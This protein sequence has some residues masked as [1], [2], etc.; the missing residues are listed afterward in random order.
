M[1]GI[2]ATIATV[3]LLLIVAVSMLLAYVAFQGIGDTST[4]IVEEEA[5]A[6]VGQST[7]VTIDNAN[8]EKVFVR[9][10]GNM[11][12]NDTLVLYVD[13]KYIEI[14][15]VDLEK[16]KVSEL[17]LSGGFLAAG[18]YDFRLSIPGS[19][20]VSKINVKKSNIITEPLF[21]ETLHEPISIFLVLDRSGSMRNDNKMEDA[22]D[23]ATS[24]VDIT[25]DL[26]EVG[27]VSFSTSARLDQQLTIDKQAVKDEIDDLSAR[28]WTAI[29][30][31]I[32]TATNELAVYG[33][34]KKIQVLLTDGR[35]TRNS[36]PEG[37]AAEAAAQNVTI[38]AI[39]LGD[40]VDEPQLM[41]IANLTGGNYYF[42]PTSEELMSIFTQ[43]AVQLQEGW[44]E[45]GGANIDNYGATCYS[46]NMCTKFSS[47]VYP[48]TMMLQ[49]RKFTFSGAYVAEASA[50]LKVSG[51]SCNSCAQLPGETCLAND[52]RLHLTAYD[53][54]DQIIDEKIG[55][56]AGSKGTG[57][58]EVKET[59]LTPVATKS[60]TFQVD[61]GDCCDCNVDEVYADNAYLS[62]SK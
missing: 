15:P 46:P 19:K 51:N 18:T 32:Y 44:V 39:G 59:W 36:D 14:N 8:S 49:N 23:A 6:F 9:N 1:K 24:F 56:W 30:D 37:R 43:I 27:L 26:D 20:A 58:V 7:S 5:E 28:G 16:N 45:V 41:L 42:S 62:I 17:N 55:N 40:D 3:M 33:L 57:W 54:Q 53:S 60:V 21:G 22:K 11:I 31:G 48:N 2:S 29:G 35:E 50:F 47:G 61:A 25:D 34:D 13:G 52:A 10:L 4:E 12:P 38:Y